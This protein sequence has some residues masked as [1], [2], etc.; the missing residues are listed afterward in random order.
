MAKYTQLRGR[1]PAFR[2]EASYQQKVDAAKDFVLGQTSN[3][4]DANVNFLARLFAERRAQKDAHEEAI[5]ELNVELEALSQLLVAAL[6]DQALEKVELAAGGSVGIKDTPYTSVSDK[7]KFMAW[8]K[9]NRMADLLTVNHQTLN[10][11]NNERLVAGQ[12]AIP[13]TEVFL[14]TRARLYGVGRNGEE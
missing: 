2:E 5:H 10:G 6:E 8:I 12:P 3:P 13:G 11:L 1:L 7:A 14:K 9:R 4:R